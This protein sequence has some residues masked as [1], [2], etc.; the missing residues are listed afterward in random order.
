MSVNKVLPWHLWWPLITRSSK[1]IMQHHTIC[2]AAR[3]F[4]LFRFTLRRYISDN[5]ATNLAGQVLEATDFR[6]II[7]L[8]NTE[9]NSRTNVFGI[10]QSILIL[11]IKTTRKMIHSNC[12][13]R[14][15]DYNN[16]RGPSSACT[17]YKYRNYNEIIITTKNHNCRVA[18]C[19]VGWESLKTRIIATAIAVLLEWYWCASILILGHILQVTTVGSNVTAILLYMQYAVECYWLA[20]VFHA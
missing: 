14:N 4:R 15:T 6:I 20:I 12:N 9:T 16:T 18:E 17:S 13:L 2:L 1:K 8:L 11:H 19:V 10:R 3:P 5:F 7:T